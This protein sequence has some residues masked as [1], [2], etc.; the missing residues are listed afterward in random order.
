MHGSVDVTVWSGDVTEEGQVELLP[1]LAE[2]AVS[3]TAHRHGVVDPAFSALR[4]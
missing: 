4:L 1:F 3:V 2:Q